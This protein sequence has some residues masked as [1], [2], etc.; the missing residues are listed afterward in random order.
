[1]YVT[2]TRTG[3]QCGFR[4]TMDDCTGAFLEQAGAKPD[5]LRLAEHGIHGNGHMM[6]LE[7]NNTQV[8]DAII[9]W[10]QKARTSDW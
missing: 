6:M 10:I 3:P 5:R 7:S 8:A 2:F 4:A 1:M 9:G